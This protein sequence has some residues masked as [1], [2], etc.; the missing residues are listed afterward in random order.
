MTSRPKESGL[1]AAR[2]HVITNAISRQ[3]KVLQRQT[4]ACAG[5]LLEVMRCML[6]EKTLM[7]VLDESGAELGAMPVDEVKVA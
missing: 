6:K 4:G 2:Q 1:A 7:I 3:A 5:E